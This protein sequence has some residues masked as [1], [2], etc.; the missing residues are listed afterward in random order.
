MVKRILL[1]LFFVCCFSHSAHSKV[2]A[3]AGFGI[4]YASLGTAR[5]GFGDWEVGKY[6]SRSFA[7]NKLFHLSKS[8]YGALG[9]GYVG[10]GAGMVAS[11]G[12]YWDLWLGIGLRME[13]YAE[14]SFN[15]YS[16]GAALLGASFNF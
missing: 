12:Y 11:F 15:N 14:Q 1:I 9:A 2:S 10:N 7:I 5:I 3:Y 6:A 4:N 16:N 13:F 8:V